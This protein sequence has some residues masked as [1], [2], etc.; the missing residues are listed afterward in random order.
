MIQILEYLSNA[1]YEFLVGFLW[2]LGFL[3]TLVKLPLRC[4]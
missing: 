3:P 1:L 4:A 2:V